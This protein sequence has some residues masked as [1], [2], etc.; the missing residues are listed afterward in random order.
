[1]KEYILPILEGE[2]TKRVST[3]NFINCFDEFLELQ[4]EVELRGRITNL[5][6]F[7]KISFGVLGD[8]LGE[9]QI[10]FSDDQI[11]GANNL[12]KNLKMG[13]VVRVSGIPFLPKSNEKSLS[14]TELEIVSQ[15]NGPF[16]DKFKGVT[17]TG[18]RRSNFPLQLITDRESFTFFDR[19]SKINM[20][21]RDNLDHL[22]FQEFE[23]PVLRKRFQSGQ[24]KPFVTHQNSLGTDVFMRPTSELELVQL[25]VAGYERVYELGKAF[26]NEGQDKLHNPEYTVLEAYAAYSDYNGMMDL[27]EF[28]VK[29]AITKAFG[30]S[31]FILNGIEIN[32]DPKWKQIT[33]DEGF[34]TFGGFT[35]DEIKDIDSL[36]K[37]ASGNGIELSGLPLVQE[38]GKLIEKIIVPQLVQPTFLKD[39]PV[40]LAPLG[41]T[42]ESDPTK[43]E[44]AWA[45]MNG[46]GFADISTNLVDPTELQRK[47]SE[48]DSY[49]GLPEKD[50]SSDPL[51]AALNYG[52][53]PTAGLGIGL[54]RLLMIVGD[55]KSLRETILFPDI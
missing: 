34:K 4:K 23:T 29:E 36:R 19:V 21:L 39:F 22:G 5:R 37:K 20:S 54:N 16:P 53:P 2:P 50:H 30:R 18:K 45:C 13:A 14:V 26:R 52:A 49:M 3:L 33:V 12:A 42:K 27:A 28:L 38:V 8:Q 15:F 17:D 25:V 43:V 11:P 55:Q 24:A 6:K 9:V 46:V 32:I 48:Q 47:L 44:R 40:D 1:M 10:V 7:K 41:K 31:H 51:V 35:L